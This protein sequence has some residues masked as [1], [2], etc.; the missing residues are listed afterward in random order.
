MRDRSIRI[1]PATR[2]LFNRGFALYRQREDQEWSLTDCISFVVMRELRIY[3]ALTGDLHFQ[4]A[5][6]VPLL[7]TR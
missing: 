2:S 6:L 5:G 1:I 3:E 4:Q 7:K